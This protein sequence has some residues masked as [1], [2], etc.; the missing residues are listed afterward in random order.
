M[1]TTTELTVKYL[2][3][4][5][6][7][8]DCL[9]HRVINYSR[10]SRKI[11]KELDIEKKSS[12]EAILIACRRYAA[13]LQKESILEEDILKVLKKSKL[14]IKNKVVVAIID[15]RIY[16]ENLIEMERKLRKSAEL[17]YAIEG[18]NAFTLILSEEFLAELQELFKQN[19]IKITKSLAMITIRSPKDLETTPGVMSYLYS[20]FGEHGINIVETMSCWTDTIFVIS[21][22]DIPVMMGYLRF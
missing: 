14:E 4:H 10:L 2:E 3:E 12:M 21:E 5:P 17:F 15:K 16:V 18:V 9:K 7:I 13:R 19:I 8:K 1:P 20:I 6:S 11:A 22:D